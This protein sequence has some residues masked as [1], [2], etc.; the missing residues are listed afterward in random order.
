ML[1]VMLCNLISHFAHANP[2]SL[3]YYYLST[4]FKLIAFLTLVDLII[5][6]LF[7]RNIQAA[8]VHFYELRILSLIEINSSSIICSFLRFGTKVRIT[9]A[10]LRQVRILN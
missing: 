1:S 6:S 3:K 2:S 5:F 8:K 10:L 9:W 7:K 4:S